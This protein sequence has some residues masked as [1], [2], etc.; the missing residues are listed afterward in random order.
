M[1]VSSYRFNLGWVKSLFWPR[2]CAQFQDQTHQLGSAIH[3]NTLKV[4]PGIPKVSHSLPSSTSLHID[5]YPWLRPHFF[6]FLN[7]SDTIRLVLRLINLEHLSQ[8]LFSIPSVLCAIYEYTLEA[9]LPLWD[10]P[11]IDRTLPP[12][13]P[14]VVMP[15]GKQ[16]L[17]VMLPYLWGQAL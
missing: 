9:L 1:M 13:K 3:F 6:F 7:V 12:F 4:E 8:W 11:I 5:L 2:H 14:E 16:Y 17:G 15:L 10:W